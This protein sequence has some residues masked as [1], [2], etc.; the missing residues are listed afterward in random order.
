MHGLFE[1]ASVDRVVNCAAIVGTEALPGVMM[2]QSTKAVAYSTVTT[3]RNAQ[4]GARLDALKI[5]IVTLS[6]FYCTTYG[7][8]VQYASQQQ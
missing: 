7:R 3:A 2:F 8:T 4:H 6:P 5:E 1:R